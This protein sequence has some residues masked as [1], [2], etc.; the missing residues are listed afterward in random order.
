[1]TEKQPGP[2]RVRKKGSEK[3]MSKT[4]RKKTGKT[5]SGPEFSGPRRDGLNMLFGNVRESFM[6]E[7]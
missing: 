3:G 2:K 6:Q 7:R 5:G 4:K 1:M